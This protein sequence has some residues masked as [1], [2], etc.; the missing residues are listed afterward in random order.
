VAMKKYAYFKSIDD[1]KKIKQVKE[2]LSRINREFGLSKDQFEVYAK[3]LK[4]KRCYDVEVDAN[5]IQKEAEK[6]WKSISS[7]IFE[8]SKKVKFE[9][10]A[11]HMSVEGK[12]NTQGIRF[13]KAGEKYKRKM[14][15]KHLL[16]WNGLEIPVKIR[17]NDYYAQMALD[18]KICFC[19]IV[20]KVIRNKD[21]YF[22]QL[23]L[24]GVPPVK[25][26]KDGTF[27]HKQGKGAV[28]VDIGVSTVAVV[29]DTKATL[30]P[31]NNQN[32]K[33]IDKEISRL[34]RKLERSRRC[35]N[36]KNYN[37]DGTVKKGVRLKWIYSFNYIKTLYRL[38]SL[39]TLKQSKRKQYHGKLTNKFLTEGDIVYVENMNFNALKARSKNTTIN[40]KTGRYN[41]KSRFGKSIQNFAPYAFLEAYKRKLGYIDKELNKINTKTFK[42]SQLN[43]TTGL[44]TKKKLNQRWNCIYN[45]K[46]QRDLYSAFL[47]QNSND[48]LNTSNI[49]KCKNKFLNFTVLH[50][51]E[52]D[53]IKNLKT[54]NLSSFGF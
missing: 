48:D 15:D 31:L 28:G 6:A 16:V 26:K 20:R 42:A 17:S 51:N 2:E 45:I 13:I 9:K 7:L 29:S 40:E 49:D 37:E 11:Q 30:I 54:K 47:L 8:G 27:R 24:E 53:R 38:R 12:K 4:N 25:L 21:M 44:Y 33:E 43:H 46:I 10:Y 36:P 18:D 50:S 32:I 41:R 23:V 19:R 5:T 14:L 35:M 22:L 39:Y 52:I 1:E 34:Q 3:Q